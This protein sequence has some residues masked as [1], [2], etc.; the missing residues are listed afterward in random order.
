MLGQSH[1]KSCP[2][3]CSNDKWRN[4]KFG[5]STREDLDVGFL[6]ELHWFPQFPLY[7]SEHNEQMGRNPC[8]FTEVQCVAMIIAIDTSTSTSTDATSGDVVPQPG[9]RYLVFPHVSLCWIS[10]SHVEFSSQACQT[11]RV[12][13][14]LSPQTEMF[15]GTKLSVHSSASSDEA[16]FRKAIGLLDRRYVDEMWLD[17]L[18]TTG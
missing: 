5:T 12:T 7:T 10:C 18:T 13:S 3:T 15:C 4:G 2:T 11:P 1:C 16:I 8:S 14:C 17:L 9:N 6:S